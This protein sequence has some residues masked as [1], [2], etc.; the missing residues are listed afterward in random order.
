MKIF[1]DLNLVISMEFNRG[2]AVPD[3][4][5][6]K[7]GT[8]IKHQGKWIWNRKNPEVSSRDLQPGQRFGFKDDYGYQHSHTY[9][10][11]KIE[12]DQVHYN[13]NST[14][15]MNSNGVMSKK[16]FVE[17][18][19]SRFTQDRPKVLVVNPKHLSEDQKIYV[20]QAF[21]DGSIRRDLDFEN[22]PEVIQ[23]QLVATVGK[24]KTPFQSLEPSPKNIRLFHETG[25]INYFTEGKVQT[26]DNGDV[27][28]FSRSKGYTPIEKLSQGD[29]IHKLPLD[30]LKALLKLR[31]ELKASV[32]PR[33]WSAA[34]MPMHDNKHAFLG[35]YIKLYT[36]TA[37]NP[38]KTNNMSAE[39]RITKQ[40]VNKKGQKTWILKNKEGETRP[41]TESYLGDKAALNTEKKNS[42]IP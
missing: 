24:K 25:L 22:L 12:G 28:I 19:G 32:D 20:D 23:K 11:R 21:N 36:S 2:R 5:L 3:G 35:D 6:S 18:I 8:R 7:D 26:R 27:E 37:A 1:L 40:F 4:T 17:K 16:E 31:P 9:E 10:I 39:Y 30:K 13:F 29:A 15:G 41:I 34:P 38:Y 33:V 42:L 14:V